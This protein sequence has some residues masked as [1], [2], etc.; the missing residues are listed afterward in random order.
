VPKLIYAYLVSLDG[1]VADEEGEFRWSAP[2]DEVLAFLTELE[3]DVRTYLYGRRI[4]EL[5]V[6]WETDDDLIA[7]SPGNAAFAEVWTAAEK[8]VFSRTLDTVSTT[9][10]RLEREFDPE[11][12]RRIKEEATSDLHVSGADLA[13]SALRAGLVDE[14]HLFVVPRVVGGGT[15]MFPAGVRLDL[16]LLDERRFSGGTTFLRYAVRR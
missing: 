5:M 4:Y 1:Y 6:A 14:V 11:L 9:R 15:P 12:V 7:S 10:T 2:D 13:A 8:I 16:E 3:Q